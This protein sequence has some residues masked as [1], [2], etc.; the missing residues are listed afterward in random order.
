[1]WSF[2]RAIE[3]SSNSATSAD[4]VKEERARKN[5]YVMEAVQVDVWTFKGQSRVLALGR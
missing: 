1:M 5:D 4:L 3:F 2:F